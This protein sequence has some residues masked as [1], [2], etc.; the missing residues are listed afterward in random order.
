MSPDRYGAVR[1]QLDASHS[2]LD[3]V[4]PNTR[5]ALQRIFEAAETLFKLVCASKK[6]PRL[7]SNEVDR[8]LR[9]LITDLYGSGS[10]EANAANQLLTGFGNWVN[11]IQS[12]RHGQEEELRGHPPID[13]TV[14]LVSQG[15][16]Y[17]RW[18]AEIDQRQ[19][20][21]QA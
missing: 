14:A 12:Y 3:M 19:N 18:L 5:D 9:Q 13:L 8:S 21:S 17:L 2:A 15:A 10:D 20:Q 11:A 7:T 4:P 6:P 1:D 16:N